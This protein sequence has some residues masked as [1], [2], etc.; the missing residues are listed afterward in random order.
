MKKLLAMVISLTL[1]NS[2]VSAEGFNYDYIV[3]NAGT[4][5]STAID[6]NLGI[7]LSKSIHSNV[8]LRANVNHRQGK[9]I[10]NG[11]IREQ[12]GIRLELESIYHRDIGANTDILVTL[13]YSYEDTKTTNISSYKLEA[14]AASLGIRQS[15]TDTIEGEIQ[16]ALMNSESNSSIQQV[17]TNLMFKISSNMSIGAKYMRNMTGADFNQTGII[18]RRKF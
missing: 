10:A 2:Y 11:S 14:H 8:A 12:T 4:T 5:S 18:I 7:G 3:A 9:W 16:Y 15:L 6:R 17:Y 1:I 13:G